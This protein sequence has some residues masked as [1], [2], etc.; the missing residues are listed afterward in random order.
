MG[1]ISCMRTPRRI[2]PG[3]TYHV[4]A[5]INRKEFA[6][7]SP[8]VKEMLIRVFRRAKERFQF[9]LVNLCIMDNHVHMMIRPGPNSS[10][11]AIMQWILSVFA[12]RYNR[13]R[14]VSGHVWYDRFRSVVVDGLRQFLATFWYIQDNPSRA[15]LIPVGEKYRYGLPELMR[16]G[17]PGLMD[18]PPP[19]LRSLQEG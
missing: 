3:A 12:V 7:A 15:G 13:Y 5:R 11:S 10:I 9:E 2:V 1:V 19:L 14:G 6:L 8:V 17:P 4:I 18:V 16:H